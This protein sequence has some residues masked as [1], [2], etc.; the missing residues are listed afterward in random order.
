MFRWTEVRRTFFSFQSSPLYYVYASFTLYDKY[1][2]SI[3]ATYFLGLLKFYFRR[4]QAIIEVCW[5]A[6]VLLENKVR[7]NFDNFLQGLE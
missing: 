2:I 5:T 3:R 1:P 4:D 6:D 7:I